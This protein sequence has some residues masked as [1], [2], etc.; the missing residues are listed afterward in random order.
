MTSRPD[1]LV[2]TGPTAVGKTA[3]AVALAKMLDTEVI[4]ADSMQVYRVLTIGTAKPTPDELGGVVYHLID[5]VDPNYQY[6]L[7]DF[8]SQASQLVEK[9]QSQGRLPIVCG[10]T[11]MYLKGLLH[12]VFNLPSRDETIRR[13]LSERCV[14]EG[15]A[16]L[17]AELQK[18]DPGANHIMPN[19]RQRILRA[20]EV[21]YVTGRPISQ[22]QQQ[23]R[24]PPRYKAAVFVLN[25]DREKLYA[26]IEERVER[27]LS[28]GWLQEVKDYLAAGYSLANPAIRALGYH[29]LISY[30]RGEMTYEEAV[31]AIKR[32]TRNFAKR[33]LTWFRAMKNAI[34]LDVAERSPAELA[35]EVFQRVTSGAECI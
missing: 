28:K 5:F 8:V 7:G 29:E 16:S 20:L 13:E 19:D 18:V 26:K 2:I 30:L 9:I 22:L 6:N 33:Q 25:M 17:Y 35:Q 31:L 32:K 34:W 4:S 10:G 12:G 27:M 3:T 11:C 1:L 21:Y 15:L 14:R 23:F 24:R